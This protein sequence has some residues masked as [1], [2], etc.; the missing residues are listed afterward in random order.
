MCGDCVEKE[1][2]NRVSDWALLWPAAGPRGV[3]HPRLA[4][5]ERPYVGRLTRIAGPI[6][7]H[8][9]CPPWRLTSAVVP[10][11]LSSREQQRNPTAITTPVDNRG[12]PPPPL[13][14][15]SSSSI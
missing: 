1:Y 10:V 6:D 7:P 13:P 3:S 12:T 11:R 14:V 9:W 8:L 15:S 2:P 5:P 4:F